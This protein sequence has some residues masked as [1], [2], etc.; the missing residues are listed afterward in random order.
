MR[1]I[2]KDDGHQKHH[3]LPAQSVINGDILFI[4]QFV[5]ES[6]LERSLPL[7]ARNHEV[8]HQ[9]PQDISH[10]AAFVPILVIR[11][12]TAIAAGQPKMIDA[13][14]AD[15]NNL[16]VTAQFAQRRRHIVRNRRKKY[17]EFKS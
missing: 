15:G 6:S 1:S 8:I 4:H 7:D 5:M 2:T 11:R 14:F 16:G 12:A 10:R 9:F 13:G 17:G 3:T